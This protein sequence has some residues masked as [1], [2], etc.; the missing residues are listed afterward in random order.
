MAKKI[1]KQ[2][3]DVLKQLTND[4]RISVVDGGGPWLCQWNDATKEQSFYRASSYVWQPVFNSMVR[5]GWIEEVHRTPGDWVY[6]GITD[7]GREAL[8]ASG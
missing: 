3:R 4:H 8:A 5:H 6:Y 1:G 7:R 2:T